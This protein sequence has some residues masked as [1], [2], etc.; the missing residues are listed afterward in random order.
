MRKFALLLL[1]IIIGVSLLGLL[2]FVVIDKFVARIQARPT[3]TVVF[4]D[5]DGLSVGSPV[6]LMGIHIGSVTKL[7]LFD[8]DILVTFRTM[9]EKYTIPDNSVATISFTGLAGSKSLEIVPLNKKFKKNRYKIYSKEPIRISS[10]F[11]VQTTI[12]ENIL[13]FCRGIL[14]V[15]SKNNVESAKVNIKN[16]SEYLQQSSQNLDQTLGNIKESGA[17][18]V[19]NTREIK[20]FMDEQNENI[21]AAYKS[22]NRLT[23]DK[24]INDNLN[25]IQST[26][27]KMSSS[28]DIKKTNEKVSELTDNINTFNAKLKNFNANLAKAKNREVQYMSGMNNTIQKASDG[29]QGVIDLAKQKMKDKQEKN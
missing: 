6:R 21:N 4:K 16:T 12:F 27:E 10:V 20:Q 3:Y 17:D 19:K 9:G 8:T 13:E 14:S 25:N 26:V 22:L 15:L 5:V 29:L 1:E 28:I 7:E 18:I 24:N 23:K 11:Q 2:L